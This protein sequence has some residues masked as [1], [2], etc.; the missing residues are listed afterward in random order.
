MN[1]SVVLLLKLFI[2]IFKGT[3]HRLRRSPDTRNES[4]KKLYNY[5]KYPFCISRQL[6]R[7]QKPFYSETP[8]KRPP[9]SIMSGIVQLPTRGIAFD[10]KFFTALIK[11]SDRCI[12]KESNHAT[13]LIYFQP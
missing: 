4:N 10:I 13:T 12:V 3:N 8:Y 5:Y 7:Q 9:D 11:T 1:R 2:R 6:N